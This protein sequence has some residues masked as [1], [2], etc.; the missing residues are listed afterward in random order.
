MLTRSNRPGSH[1]GLTRFARSVSGVEASTARRSGS[2]R[3]SGEKDDGLEDAACWRSRRRKRVRSFGARASTLAGRS[4][5]VAILLWQSSPRLR[6]ASV[7]TLSP[8]HAGQHHRRGPVGLA[9]RRAVRRRPFAVAGVLAR[10]HRAVIVVSIRL[11]CWPA[12]ALFACC[13]GCSSRVHRA[14]NQAAQ[15][16]LLTCWPR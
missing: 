12:A 11:A 10:G 6:L 13:A 5:A 4:P 14:R 16:A 2:S 15:R 8:G 9:P 3:G 1:G 7:G